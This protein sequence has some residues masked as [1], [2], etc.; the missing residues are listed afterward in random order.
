MVDWMRAVAR[1]DD[2]LE[3]H[4]A[5]PALERRSPGRG[6]TTTRVPADLDGVRPITGPEIAALQPR[7]GNAAVCQL[8][9]VQRDGLDDAWTTGGSPPANEGAGWSTGGP[10]PGGAGPVEEPGYGPPGTEPDEPAGKEDVQ[11][12]RWLTYSGSAMV[13]GG[14]WVVIASRPKSGGEPGVDTIRIT[15]T[16]GEYGLPEPSPHPDVGGYLATVRTWSSADD[17]VVS[18]ASGLTTVHIG[19]AFAP[20]SGQ[21]LALSEAAQGGGGGAAAA[22]SSGQLLIRGSVGPAVKDLQIQLGIEADGI[23]GPGTERAVRQFQAENGLDADGIVGPKT[24]AALDFAQTI[25]ATG[26]A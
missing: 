6:G 18:P 13:V 14:K 26:G 1:A 23:F 3:A 7:V 2:R 5:V 20:G 19:Q 8:L 15:G 17:A 25:P 11:L 21:H 22:G 24:H 9:Q 16:T 12:N 10:V 4:R